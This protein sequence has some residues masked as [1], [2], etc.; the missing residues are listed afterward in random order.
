MNLN[1]NTIL[2]DEVS[3]KY[4][5]KLWKKLSVKQKKFVHMKWHTTI[6]SFNVI[7]KEKMKMI[8]I[9]LFHKENELRYKLIQPPDDI[10]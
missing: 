3:V 9:D 2:Y 10:K 8:L 1:L 6:D 4:F 5:N 7:K